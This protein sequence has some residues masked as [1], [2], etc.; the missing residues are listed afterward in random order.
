MQNI[1]HAMRKIQRLGE[2]KRNLN[3]ANDGVKETKLNGLCFLRINPIIPEISNKKD[4]CTIKQKLQET[5]G[6]L[7][8]RSKTQMLVENIFKLLIR[9]N[10]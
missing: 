7:A 4:R 2:E 1:Q 6:S 8:N 10:V 5:S 9:L 3:H